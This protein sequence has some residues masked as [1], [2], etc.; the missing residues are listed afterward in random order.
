[1]VKLQKDN[2]VYNIPDDLLYVP[3]V[4]N[5]GHVW[6]R[7]EGNKARIGITDYGQKQLKEIV[8]VE[9]PSPGMEV[10]MLTFEGETPKSKPIGVIESQKTSIELYAPI[11]GTVKEINEELEDFPGVINQDPYD[12]G[13]VLV[14]LPSKIER[15][16][17]QLWSAEEYAKVLE[18]L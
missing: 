4:G 3:S 10:E 5:I 11:S 14:L 18:E 9:L 12:D 8:Y 17:E 16:K 7:I 2:N 15:E 6:V 13:W 1:M